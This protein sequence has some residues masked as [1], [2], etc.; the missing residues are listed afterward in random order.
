MQKLTLLLPLLLLAG[1]ANTHKPKPEEPPSPLASVERFYAAPVVF[2]FDVPEDWDLPPG[3][4]EGKH[5]DF[6]E[7]WLK[8]LEVTRRAPI[9]RLEGDVPPGGAVI[10]LVV[11]EIDLGF[12]GGI[13]RKPAICKGELF[14]DDAQ[15]NNLMHWDVT[16]KTPGDA[17]WQWYTYGGRLETAHDA[18]AVDAISW[19]QRERSK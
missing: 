17:G 10:R 11:H 18:F 5:K 1:C 6:S 16:F 12:Y 9:S 2:D 19:I 13:V 4:F 3:E 15:G 14:I 7:A 8:R